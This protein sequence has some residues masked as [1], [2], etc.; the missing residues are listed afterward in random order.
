MKISRMHDQPGPVFSFEF[1]PPK[2]QKSADQ[3][4]ATVAEL[5][6]MIDPDFVSVTYGAGGTTRERTLQ[7]VARIQ[8]ELKITSMAHL[9]CVG[10]DRAE[11][12]RIGG[13]LAEDGIENILVLRGDP[14]KGEEQFVQAQGGFAH[15][16]DLAGFLREEFQFDLG[17]A[18]YPEAHPESK[19]V[20]DDMEWTAKKVTNGVTFL[21][22]QLFFENR[23]YWSFVERAR[24][25]GIKVP[26]VPGIMPITNVGQIERFT[27]M[28]GAGL[29][30][31]LADRLDRCRE[32]P[33]T[34]MAIGI[35]HAVLQC[36]ELLERGA[37]GI[38]FYT[39]N[40]SPATCAIMAALRQI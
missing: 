15:A 25:A 39:L 23:T 4:M 14:P 30:P 9:T 12:R 18:C 13:L 7:C 8:R 20:A 28:C 26:I 11:L 36:R 37:P 27:K 2:T 19:T 17:G 40:K 38:H 35:E 32:D 34:V 22:T 24:K 3:L 16:S 21:T 10:H 29:P 6:E 31:E 5:K 33:A 1:F